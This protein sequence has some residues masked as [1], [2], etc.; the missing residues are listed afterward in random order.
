MVFL[1]VEQV[2]DILEGILSAIPFGIGWLAIFFNKH[3]QSWHDSLSKCYV[4]YSPKSKSTTNISREY[5]KSTTN[6]SDEYFGIA[7]AELDNQT[8]NK[9]L[10]TKAFVQYPENENLQKSEYIKLR[11]ANLEK[12]RKQEQEALEKERKQEQEAL[13]KAEVERRKAYDLERALERSPF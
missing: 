4:I 5:A 7:Q 10:W 13:E 1:L 8:Y 9:N 11:V 6:I 3:N 12:E 2:V